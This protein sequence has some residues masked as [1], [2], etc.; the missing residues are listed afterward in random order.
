MCHLP[1]SCACLPPVLIARRRTSAQAPATSPVAH[2]R[3]PDLR[4]LLCRQAR[5]QGEEECLVSSNA[6]LVS[7]RSCPQSTFQSK[8][9]EL[10]GLDALCIIP[11]N[12]S[13]RRSAAEVSGTAHPAERVTGSGRVL[14]SPNLQEGPASRDRSRRRS[15]DAGGPSRLHPECCPQYPIAHS[16][17]WLAVNGVLDLAQ[18]VPD[19]QELVLTGPHVETQDK[20]STRVRSLPPKLAVLSLRVTAIVPVDRGR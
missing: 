19:L 2:Q 17:A 6:R 7:P 15:L 14:R 11:R 5:E 9:L 13:E 20:L 10:L 12:H 3:R 18:T 16:P 1:F 4:A 8:T